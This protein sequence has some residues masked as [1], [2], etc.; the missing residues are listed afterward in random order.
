MLTRVL[1]VLAATALL[2]GGPTTTGPTSAAPSLSAGMIESP[3]RLVK[4]LAVTYTERVQIPGQSPLLVAEF[5]DGRMIAFRPCRY[6]DGSGPR[7]RHA[8][9]Y[10]NARARG[11]KIGTSFIFYGK[12]FYPL[13]TRTV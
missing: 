10:W 8:G 12:K 1:T 9:C 13:D 7:E 11:N 2:M 3:D 4:T 6:E 5:N